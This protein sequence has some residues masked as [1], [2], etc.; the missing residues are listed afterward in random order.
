[1]LLQIKTL[2]TLG[3]WTWYDGSD[4]TYTNWIDGM[5]DDKQL[6]ASCPDGWHSLK[7]S[8]FPYFC[9]VTGIISLLC[10]NVKS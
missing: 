2:L 6:G 3:V 10:D 5:P 7:D 9:Q 8:A 4:V 1:M